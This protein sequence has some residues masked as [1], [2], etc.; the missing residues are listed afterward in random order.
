M[1]F[2]LLIA[3]VGCSSS[4]SPG[5]RPSCGPYLLPADGVVCTDSLPEFGCCYTCGYPSSPNL[6]TWSTNYCVQCPTFPFDAGLPNCHE[7]TCD[8]A[9]VMSRAQCLVCSNADHEWHHAYCCNPSMPGL[10]ID[11]PDAG[12]PPDAGD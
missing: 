6:E 11:A 5:R 7:L 10:C 9:Q 1:R 2:A 4:S 3:I 8:T 12:S